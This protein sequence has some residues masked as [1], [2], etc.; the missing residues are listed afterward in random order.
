MTIKHPASF[1]DDKMLSRKRRRSGTYELES[2]STTPEVVSSKKVRL[3][4]LTDLPVI[5]GFS[6][7][8]RCLLLILCLVVGLS[9]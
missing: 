3:S 6:P 5:E 8:G 1:A 4:A 7:L 9:L 2:P